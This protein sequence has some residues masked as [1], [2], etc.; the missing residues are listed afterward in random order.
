MIAQSKGMR[1][2]EKTIRKNG[3]KWSNISVKKYHHN[4]GL[5]VRSGR[6]SLVM[7]SEVRDTS[8]DSDTHDAPH[9]CPTQCQFPHTRVDANVSSTP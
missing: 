2:T 4:P 3:R 1:R 7:I 9:V 5:G 6:V 8:E